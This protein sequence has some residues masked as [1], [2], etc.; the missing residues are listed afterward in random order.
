MNERIEAVAEQLDLGLPWRHAFAQLGQAFYVYVPIRNNLPDNQDPTAERLNTNDFLL[1]AVDVDS[2]HALH[3]SMLKQQLETAVNSELTASNVR[4][5]GPETV[6]ATRS[7][8]RW[9]G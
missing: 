1:E 4:V 7:S 6:G 2:A 9:Y 8:L 5:I 3:Q